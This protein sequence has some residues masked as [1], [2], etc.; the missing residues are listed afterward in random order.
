MFL[1]SKHRATFLKILLNKGT[2][3]D[4][5]ANANDFSCRNISVSIIYMKPLKKKSGK[6]SSFFENELESRWIDSEKSSHQI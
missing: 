6:A 1:L 2:I 3:C 4:W 5:E